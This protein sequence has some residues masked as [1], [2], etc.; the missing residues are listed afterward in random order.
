MGSSQSEPL[1]E[2]QLWHKNCI[3]AE[4]FFI[5]V[6]AMTIIH[7]SWRDL[8]DLRVARF[9]RRLQ[10]E[11]LQYQ[12]KLIHLISGVFLLLNQSNE[13]LFGRVLFKTGIVELSCHQLGENDPT[14]PQNILERRAFKP[15]IASSQ[16]IGPLNVRD[17]A[18]SRFWSGSK[19]CQ[20]WHQIN[21]ECP[22][23]RLFNSGKL[24]KLFYYPARV[25]F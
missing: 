10:F 4:F 2:L 20:K 3:R 5:V 11:L 16:R 8:R 24:R 15:I 18:S 25:V 19:S 13:R 22:S 7:N 6:F 9:I 17:M 23:L 1:I 12:A 21:C 14:K